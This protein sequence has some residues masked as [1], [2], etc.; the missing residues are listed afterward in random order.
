MSSPIFLTRNG[1]ETTFAKPLKRAVLR[2]KRLSF[3]ARGL[4]CMLW[5][6][7][8]NWTFYAS[9]IV[10]FSPGG[11]TQLRGY[12]NELKSF[13][14]LHIRVKKINATEA[15]KL[16][17]IAGKTYKTGQIIGKQW[18]LNHPDLWAIEAPLS[19]KPTDRFS[20]LRLGEDTGKP[21]HE[22]TK[23]KGFQTEGSINNKVLP[24]PK[25]EFLIKREYAF[26]AQ[27]SLKE[28]EIAETL[29][30]KTDVSTAQAILDELAARLIQNKI[31]SAPLSY[32][33]SLIKSA[34]SG[35]FIPEAGITLAL[36]REKLLKEKNS[37]H[38]SKSIPK[39]KPADLQ[40]H[41]Q[42]MHETLRKRSNE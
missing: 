21:K 20:E 42:K 12:I 33:R 18:V 24:L 8:T 10:L 9:H 13:G 14:A 3:G 38:D 30:S 29:L 31:H 28:C 37:G 4:F 35:R 7:P 40:K 15:I 26:P 36:K 17:A 22:N 6:F 16:S 34:E 25:S 5:D 27:L 32:L 39:P 1:E 19:E 11:I 23:P 41:I 2:D